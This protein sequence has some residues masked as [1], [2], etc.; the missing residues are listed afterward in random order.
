MHCGYF[1]TTGK[2]NCSCF[3]T[4]TVVGG[5]RPLPSE[6]CAEHVSHSLS[7]IAELLVVLIYMVGGCDSGGLGDISSGNDVAPP[8]KFILYL[9]KK[10]LLNLVK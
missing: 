9:E 4:P 6:I 5:R 1:D 2:G 10:H 7:A 3:L 8:T